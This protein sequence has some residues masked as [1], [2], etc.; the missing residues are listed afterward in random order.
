MSA[1]R[2]D[3]IF[4]DDRGNLVIGQP[5]NLPILVWGATTLLKFVF[6]SGNIYLVLDP[7]SFGSLFTWAW[8]ELFDGVNYFRRT[9]GLVVIGSAIASRI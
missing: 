9:L 4:H 8:L 7:I 5:P 2:F 6:T 3:R 1:T